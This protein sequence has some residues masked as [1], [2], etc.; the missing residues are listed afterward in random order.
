L[1]EAVA[2]APMAIE[3]EPDAVVVLPARPPTAMACAP[4]AVPPPAEYCACATF[5]LAPATSTAA[6]TALATDDLLGLPRAAEISDAATQAPRA[7][8]QIER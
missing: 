8:F 7:S 4:V 3:V 2:F 1:P 6:A 5:M